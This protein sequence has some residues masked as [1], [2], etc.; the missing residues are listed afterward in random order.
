MLFDYMGNQGPRD[1][2]G[3][4]IFAKISGQ[5][6]SMSGSTVSGN[7]TSASSTAGT[8]DAVTSGGGVWGEFGQAIVTGSSF[9]DNSLTANS[10]GGDAILTGG[11]L[12]ATADIVT[13]KTSHV[14]GSTLTGT[15]GGGAGGGG[16]G[17]A[18]QGDLTI[19][20]SSI[21]SGTI[22]LHT[23]TGEARA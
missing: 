19:M 5:P 14:I 12:Q 1:C 16:G 18:V 9:V 22:E 6:F 2:L 4:G 3:G 13:V 15:G 17:L 21:S 20:S 10:S 8:T 11:G 7:A 23:G